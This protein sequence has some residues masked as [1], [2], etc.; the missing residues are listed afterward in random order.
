MQGL[1]DT[2]AI[3]LVFFNHKK[4]FTPQ[5]FNSTQDRPLTKCTKDKSAV[6]LVTVKIYWPKYMYTLRSKAIINKGNNYRTQPITN[7]LFKTIDGCSIDNKCSKVLYNTFAL[8]LGKF[9][10]LA[11]LLRSFSKITGETGPL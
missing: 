9:V 6:A 4:S 8:Q 1:S 3:P 5:S 2:L 10:V 7:I 11:L